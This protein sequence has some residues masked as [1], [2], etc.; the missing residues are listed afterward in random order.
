MNCLMFAVNTDR[1]DNV[2]EAGVQSRRNGSIDVANTLVNFVREISE[3]CARTSRDFL[4]CMKV[5]D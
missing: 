3:G 5:S 4:Q 2:M 1:L